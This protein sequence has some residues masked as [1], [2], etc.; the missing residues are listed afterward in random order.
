MDAPALP[1]SL[2]SSQDDIPALVSTVEGGAIASAEPVFPDA[3]LSPDSV[4]ET[5][6]TEALSAEQALVSQ[7]PSPDVRTANFL[8]TALAKVSLPTEFKPSSSWLPSIQ[9]TQ[10]FNFISRAFRSAKLDSQINQAS[11]TASLN[12]S[13]SAS[14]PIQ[15]ARSN[16]WKSWAK[17]A[18]VEI[19][20]VDTKVQMTTAENDTWT[21]SFSAQCL[22]GEARELSELS[23]YKLS[24]KEKTLGYVSDRDQAYLLAQQ[25]E[26]LIHKA[27]FEADE[28]RF[29]L[30]GEGA[31]A[32][33]K[34]TAADRALF[35]VDESM[36]EAVGYSKEW[37]AIAW[38]NNLR[39]ALE[40]EPLSVG[41]MQMALEQM[42]QSD[43]DLEGDA[44]WY[45]PYFHGRMTANGET[46]NQHDL[47][48]AHKSL[49]F[50]TYLKVRNL[51]NDRTVVVRVNDRG[52]YVGDRSLDLSNAAAKCLGSE[53]VG[54]ISYEAT[55]L[56]KAK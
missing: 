15:W 24:L 26:R 20:P 54:V 48:V 30:V 38:T 50:G 32:K 23:A 28:I 47:T 53:D 34:L 35:S 45:G 33:F 8:S 7:V 14:V 2:L 27:D 31:A 43:I 44:S 25:L 55:L 13:L 41:D 3:V 36:A 29:E 22:I 56:R 6:S 12:A 1:P 46:Y 17:H 39:T 10:S 19:T 52:P 21:A 18:E 11:Q 37:A 51:N 16:N 5:L 42:E 40:A 9:I 4:V 49:P